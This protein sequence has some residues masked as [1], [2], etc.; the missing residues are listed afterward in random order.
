MKMI[1]LAGRKRGLLQYRHCIAFALAALTIA[2]PACRRHATATG[3][4]A[5]D[6]Q[7][8]AS[9]EEAGK[10]LAD[11]ARN[12]NQRQMQAIFGP[13]SNDI[14]SSGNAGDDKVSFTG[15]AA[16]YD[17]LNRWRRLENGSAILM[18]GVSNTVFPVPLKKELS[19]QW[20]FDTAAGKLELTN[21]I[22]A[23]NELAAIDV[24]AAL[25]D[26]QIEYL[27]QQHDGIK[28][29]ARKFI[30]DPGKEDGLYWPTAPGKPRSP[31]GPLVAYATDEGAKV[32]PS[33]HKPFHGYYFGMLMTQGF[34]ANGGLRDYV[35]GGIM[36]RGFGFIAYPAEYG[37]SGVMTFEINQGGIIFQKDMGEA[38]KVQA[39]FITQFNPDGAWSEVRQ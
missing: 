9:P 16:A 5:H 33:L 39:P 7:T 27:L 26:S 32:Q 11:A 18:V 29:F 21:R 24:C 34:W 20:Y 35:R 10:V 19:G 30:S 3:G 23:R 36:N 8:F 37:V 14:F 31:L 22:V 2:L 1:S 17:R 25:A 6:Q 13:D 38:T 15:F 28:Q 12:N 4:P